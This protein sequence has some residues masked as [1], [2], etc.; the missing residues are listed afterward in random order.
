[1]NKTEKPIVIGGK[2]FVPVKTAPETLIV[3]KPIYP[4]K[5]GKIDVFTIGNK[6]YIPV[7]VI[8]R[9]YRSLFKPK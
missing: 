9:V 5:E 7:K 4:T 6:T 8:P 2:T 1:M 3:S